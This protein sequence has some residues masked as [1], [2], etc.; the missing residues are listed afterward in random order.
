[1]QIFAFLYKMAESGD[2]KI[3]SDFPTS[4]KT[5]SL[6]LIASNYIFISNFILILFFPSVNSLILAIGT[7]SFFLFCG[8]MHLYLPFFL[9]DI[10][11]GG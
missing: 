8:C 3:Y 10:L 1:M 9:I 5:N 6:F 7:R 4:F 11:V 2:R